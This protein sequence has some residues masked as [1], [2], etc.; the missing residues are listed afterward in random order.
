MGNVFEERESRTIRKNGET[1]QEY[2][3]HERNDF[4]TGED[5]IGLDAN[6]LVDLVESRDFKEEIRIYVQLNVLEI[7]TTNIALGEARHVLI[8][9]RNYSFDNATLRLNEV[10]KEFNIRVVKHDPQLAE[11]AEEWLQTLKGKMFIHKFNTF[12]ND[13]RILA[14]LFYQEK[15]NLYITEDTDVEKAVKILSIPLR[16][17]IIGEASNLNG[18]KIKEFFKQNRKA[19]HKKRKPF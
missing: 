6:V 19:H 5:I 2:R 13:L 15:V 1:I 8:K 18:Q 11:K 7:C 9:K 10:I 3:H 17:K 12:P 14:N 16:I 4:I